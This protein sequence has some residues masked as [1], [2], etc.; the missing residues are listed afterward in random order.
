MIAAGQTTEVGLWN[1]VRIQVSVRRW[2]RVIRKAMVDVDRDSAGKLSAYLALGLPI[3]GR[4]ATLADK[5]CRDEENRTQPSFRWVL[6]ENVDQYRSADRVT[7]H[8][9]TVVQ[10]RKLFLQRR[11][12]C[13]VAWIVFIGHAWIADLVTRPELAYQ[14]LDKLAVPLIMNARATALNEEQLAFHVWEC[15]SWQC[16]VIPHLVAVDTL[17]PSCVNVA[18]A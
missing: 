2:G 10:A 15:N 3:I 4:P 9:R 6:R 14:T 18:A 1:R 13:G 8:D 5:R 7:D 12:P 16:G 11:P 17:L